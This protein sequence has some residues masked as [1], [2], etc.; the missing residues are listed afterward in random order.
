MT[1]MDRA[2]KPLLHHDLGPGDADAAAVGLELV[3]TALA[4]DG[5]VIGDF[6]GVFGTQH[7]TQVEP[8]GNRSES[9][10]GVT[11]LH[12][13]A[14]R[15]PGDE[16]PVEV[17]GSSGRVGDAVMVQFCNQPVLEGLVDP[18]APSSSLRRVGKDDLYCQC[19]HGGFE[20]GG[21]SVTLEAMGAAVPGSGE[22]AGFVEIQCR[23]EAVLPADVIEYLEAGVKRLLWRK[24][25]VEG[26]AGGIVGSQHECRMWPGRSKPR[27]RA[28]V[29]EDEFAKACP[30]L[31]PPAVV[32]PGVMATLGRDVIVPEPAAERLPVDLES[33]LFFQSFGEVIVVVL[34]ELA[35]VQSEYLPSEAGGLGIGRAAAAVAVDDALVSLAAY[36]GF[37]SEG[38]ADGEAEHSGG[39]AGRQTREHLPDNIQPDQ[40]VLLE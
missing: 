8:I 2:V 16:H 6:A 29:D 30:A 13:E 37:E 25:A 3:G 40:L 7:R 21:L 9:G 18:L 34:G 17:V 33:V 39:G 23:R 35:T 20:T 36:P 14:F 10:P 32:A 26:Y 4:A 22:L 11:W 31:S 28:A 15:I 5:V 38:L 19:L 24:E 1:D 12:P 27:V